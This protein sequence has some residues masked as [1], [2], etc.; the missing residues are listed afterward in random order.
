MSLSIGGAK[1]FLT[2]AHNWCIKIIIYNETIEAGVKLHK[3]IHREFREL[4]AERKAGQQMGRRGQW[5]RGLAPEYLLTHCQ[6]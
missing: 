2:N 3:R 5:E 6:R 1:K 4:R